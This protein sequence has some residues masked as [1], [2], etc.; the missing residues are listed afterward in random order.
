ML[1]PSLFDMRK[2][3]RCR[4]LKPTTSFSRHKN[5]ADGINPQCKACVS[6][7]QRQWYEAN[8]AK[9]IERSRLWKDNNREQFRETS[10]KRRERNREKVLARQREWSK[11]H[12]ETHRKAAAVRRQRQLSLPVYLI[13][14]KDYR[15]LYASPCVACGRQVEICLDHII[16]VSRGG[17][18]GIGN[19]Q[20]L[21]RPCNSSKGTML[22]VEWRRYLARRKSP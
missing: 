3:S 12:P 6:V 13:S 4:E 9:T 16:P 15:R 18:Y 5:M 17:H 2:C 11:T 14:D 1:Q 10:A 20:P 7:Y 8:R 22:L 19:A 21:C